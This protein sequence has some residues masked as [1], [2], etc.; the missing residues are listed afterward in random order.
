MALLAAGGAGAGERFT[1]AVFN[2]QNLFDADGEARFED[3]RSDPPGGGPGYGPEQLSRK[4]RAVGSVLETFDGGR[5]PAVVVVQELER[6]L[7]PGGAA[8]RAFE[9]D[10]AGWLREHRDTSAEEMLNDP[11]ALARFRSLPAHAWLLKHLDDQG[12]RGYEGATPPDREGTPHINAIFS[13][14]PVS[15]LRAHPIPKAREI[16]EA[17]LEVNGKRLIVFA[18]HWK[19]GAS[20]PEREPIRVRG[21]RVLRERIDARLARDPFADIVVAGD[22]NS[23]Y[24]HAARFP[25]LERTGINHVLG[26]QGDERAM[27][28]RGG[29]ALYNLWFELPPSQRL[30]EVYRGKRSTLMHLL[31]ARGL[32]DTGGVGYV[33]GSFGKRAR[34]GLNADAAGRP[35]RWRLVEG[36]VGVSDHFPVYAEF[37]TRD[38]RRGRF[39]SLSDPSRGENVPERE[40][41]FAMKVPDLGG[42]PSAREVAGLEH[43]AFARHYGRLMSARARVLEA[44]P[45][46]LEVGEHA[47]AAYAPETSL[48]RRLA[49]L[50]GGPARRIAV[51]PSF[52]RGRRQFLVHA[53]E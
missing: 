25:G 8:T 34:R 38:G 28:R 30:S 3:Y 44:N 52:H 9:A 41:R 36:G 47:I 5:G 26:S 6:D 51:E 14:Y 16:L 33:D 42:L 46:R 31:V 45:L 27:L 4:L 15:E 17:T 21:A 20:D 23:H 13:R 49:E 37:E 10:P 1:V 32:Y 40:P 19:S 35:L 43:E 24:N 22:L 12:M 7:T 53:M 29:P 39:V 2:V 11:D 48:Y 18:N 50:E